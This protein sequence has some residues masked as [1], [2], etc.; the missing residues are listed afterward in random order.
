[1]SLKKKIG[2]VLSKI[3]K[4]LLEAKFKALKCKNVL[5]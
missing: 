1:M 5:H 2:Y 3:A 4:M